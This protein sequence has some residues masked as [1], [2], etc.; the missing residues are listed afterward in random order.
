MKSLILS[1]ALITAIPIASFAG[2]LKE[3]TIDQLE[4]SLLNEKK[5]KLLFFYTSWCT[6]CKPVTLSTGL[7]KDK[8][9]FIS[10]DTE[11]EAIDEFVKRMHYDSI[12]IEPREKMANLV[13]LSTKLGIKLMTLDKEGNVD[14]H[15]PYIV[16]LDKDNKVIADDIPI[17]DLEKYFK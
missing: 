6:H 10:I 1:L 7:K 3:L 8:I 11:R 4:E 12:Y 13:E 16:Y 17:E 9:T 2:T 5:D 15:F 14:G